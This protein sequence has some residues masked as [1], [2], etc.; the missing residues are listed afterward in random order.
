ME[1]LILVLELTNHL[2]LPGILCLEEA[3]VECPCALLLESHDEAFLEKTTDV[4]WRLSR[5]ADG[6]TWLEIVR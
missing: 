1:G 3:L 4:E 5:H 2:D 6:D